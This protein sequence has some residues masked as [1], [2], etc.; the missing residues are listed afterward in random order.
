MANVVNFRIDLSKMG[1]EAMAFDELDLKILSLLA[2]DSKQKYAD[3]AERL[4]LSAPA[5]HARVKKLEQTGVISSYG[6]NI[7]AAKIDLKLCAFIRIAS[8]GVTCGEV[9]NELRSMR[10]IEELHTVAGEECFL[11]KVRTSDT[12]ALS[13]LLDRIRKVRGI[14]KTITSVVLTTHFDR[15]PDPLVNSPN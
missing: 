11:A 6:I 10:E 8:E 1:V 3:L 5:V 4:K 12:E 14:R 13:G 9:F 7:D 2:D 15:G